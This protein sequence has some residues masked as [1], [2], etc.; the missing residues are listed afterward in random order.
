MYQN[1]QTPEEIINSKLPN[2]RIVTSDNEWELK[3][4]NQFEKIGF[5]TIPL[6]NSDRPDAIIDLSGSI[7]RNDLLGYIRSN[8]KYRT[9]CKIW[10]LEY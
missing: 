9:T 2:I 10:Q 4:C 7:N 3:I 1:K 8:K 5:E 6:S